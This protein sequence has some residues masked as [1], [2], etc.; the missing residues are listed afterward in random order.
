MRV[1]SKSLVLLAFLLAGCQAVPSVEG[2]LIE[3]AG[4]RPTD[5]QA[6]AAVRE[7]MARELRDVDSV[8][9]FRVLSFPE[10]VVGTTLGNG[11]EEAWLMCV[12]YNA[13]NAYGG[14]SGLQTHAYLMRFS[15]AELVPVSPVNWRHQS[16]SC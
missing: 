14:Y 11:L 4:L 10:V 1:R 13:A 2:R 3:S 9:Q 16:R 6:L 7:R 12:E 15:G 8:K 5:A